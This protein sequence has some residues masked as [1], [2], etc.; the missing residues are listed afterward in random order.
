[1]TAEEIVRVF[2]KSANQP[3]EI[4]LT[5]LSIQIQYVC[6]AK[7]RLKTGKFSTTSVIPLHTDYY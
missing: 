1:M 7:E 4:T 5:N 6:L 3:N 2:T